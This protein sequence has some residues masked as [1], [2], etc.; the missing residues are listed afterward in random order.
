[1][2][3]YTLT[4]GFLNRNNGQK[5]NAALNGGVDG[6]AGTEFHDERKKGILAAILGTSESD[7]DQN[8]VSSDNFQT[9]GGRGG[10]KVSYETLDR[11]TRSRQ[12]ALDDLVVEENRSHGAEAPKTNGLSPCI[13]AKQAEEGRTGWPGKRRIEG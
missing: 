2:L 1:M 12:E 8:V 6:G 11:D 4:M 9:K 5:L 3:K 7:L 10:R 13:L